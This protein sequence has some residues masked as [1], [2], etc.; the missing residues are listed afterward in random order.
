[1]DLVQ[2][3][4]AQASVCATD[5]KEPFVHQESRIASSSDAKGYRVAYLHIT[6]RPHLAVRVA[7]RARRRGTHFDNERSLKDRSTKVCAYVYSHP[8][9]TSLTHGG[10]W[11]RTMIKS[12]QQGQAL[13][14]T[15]TAAVWLWWS[16][17]VTFT[18][19]LSLRH[20]FRPE[21]FD[22]LV[23]K[24]PDASG[25]LPVRRCLMTPLNMTC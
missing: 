2:Q 5:T 9:T 13:E 11:W 24:P 20:P 12:H 3:G 10:L 1:M 22:H 23:P 7:V 16:P 8:C 25:R 14:G 4:R 21:P 19:S 18:H 6:R 15:E 17:K